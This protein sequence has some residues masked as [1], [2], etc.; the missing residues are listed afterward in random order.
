M[1]TISKYLPS[2]KFIISLSAA[3]LIIIVSLILTF[4]KDK[5]YVSK[6]DKKVVLSEESVFEAFKLADAD[7]DGLPDWQENLY[8]TDPKKADT[9][10]DGTNDEDEMKVDRDPLK[11]NTAK[12]AQEPNDKVEAQIIEEEKKIE[13][14]YAKLNDTQKMARNFLSQYL[15]SQ[16]SDRQMT[17]AEMAEV[18]DRMI[19]Q[20]DIKNMADKYSEGDVK[21]YSGEDRTSNVNE[22]FKN[23][24]TIIG[25]EVIPNTMKGMDIISS[26]EKNNWIM[27]IKKNDEIIK[28]LASSSEKI[29]ALEA[30][31]I[32]GGENLKLANDIYKLSLYIQSFNKINEDPLKSITG[33]KGYTD[34]V[35]DI[36]SIFQDIVLKI[37]Y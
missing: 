19:S 36:Q 8:G 11:A 28:V 1:I 9:D 10:G 15:A 12:I 3:I 14:E 22:Y 7:S 16:P 2:K 17:E 20:V 5:V 29:I 4:Y 26:L 31:E 34:T 27:N 21:I 37:N 24:S 23:L 35:Y 13:T 18:V 25:N 33:L 6:S 30:P 32:I